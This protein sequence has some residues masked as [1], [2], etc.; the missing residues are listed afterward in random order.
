MIIIF[1]IVCLT[2]S[3]IVTI[4]VRQANSN[5]GDD[6]FI[7][8]TAIRKQGDKDWNDVIEA[9]VGDIIDYQIQYKN[10]SSKS[11]KNVMVKFVL[12]KNVEYIYGSTVLYNVS[13]PDGIKMSD[14][15]ATTGVNI[16][17]YTSNSNAYVRFS[18]IVRNVNLLD[19]ENSLTAWGQVGV[20]QETKQDSAAL[21]V[22]L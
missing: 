6:N 21:I 1:I 16:G 17:G 9:K 7:V 13:N 10:T 14:A 5:F 22:I 4:A 3:I 19:G 20:G 11:T 15:I 12:S 18:A 8:E 2:T